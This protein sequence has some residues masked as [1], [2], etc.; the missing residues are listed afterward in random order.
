MS[1]RRSSDDQPDRLRP[2][3]QL[4]Q[5][6][7][8]DAR[9][10]D[11]IIDLVQ[12]QQS[13]PVIEIGP[14]EGVLTE[15]LISRGVQLTALEVDPDAI[16]YLRE[17]FKSVAHFGVLDKSVLDHELH[18]QVEVVGNLP[19]NISSQIMFWLMAQQSHITR[20]TVMVQ[21]EVGA[22]LAADPGSKT[23]GILS[24]LLPF[25]FEVQYQF[26][27]SP[28]AFRPP[29][30]VQSAVLTLDR[31]PTPAALDVDFP[32]LKRIVKAAFNQRR[33]TLRNALKA[34][35]VVPPE[36]L[37]SQRAEQ[38]SL[39]DFLEICRSQQSS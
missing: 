39:A 32:D 4:G 20:A 19:Y 34:I 16:T 21:H 28:G 31:K 37:A 22:R 5:H 3:K 27:V 26:K 38:L 35:D 2:K 6:F 33:K 17:R 11:R 29:P 7:L 1:D 9:V 15:R 12:A 10:V 23:Y 24:V 36:H 18:E 8:H 14:G 13:E 30:R 25:Y